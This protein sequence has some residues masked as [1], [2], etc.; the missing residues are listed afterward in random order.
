MPSFNTVFGANAVTA[1]AST[2]PVTPTT[3]ATSSVAVSAAGSSDAST[4]NIQFNITAGNYTYT[5][6]NFAKGDVLHFPAGQ[7]PTLN[8]VNYT[9]GSV[10]VQY[11]SGGTTTHI[12]LTG[13]TLSQDAVLGFSDLNTVFGAG[14]VV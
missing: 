2:T 4:G 3:G 8:N 10:D 11:E 14:T 5:I 7:T 1:T 13:L 9:D 12:V 6:A